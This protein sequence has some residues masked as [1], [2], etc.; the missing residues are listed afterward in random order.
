MYK[1][2]NKKPEKGQLCICRCPEWCD[3]GYQIATYDGEGFD[4]DN[5]PNGSFN[6]YV[7]AWLALNE[8]GEPIM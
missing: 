3:E 1:G 6:E 7:I 8:D 5:A 4:Y 2:R